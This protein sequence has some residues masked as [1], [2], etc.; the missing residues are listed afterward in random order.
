MIFE[1][2]ARQFTTIAQCN[3]ALSDNV[4]LRHKNAILNRKTQIKNIIDSSNREAYKIDNL[5][6]DFV[7]NFNIDEDY[8]LFE[9]TEE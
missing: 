4:E 7:D 2:W 8:K 1:S 5:K 9:G 6:A 3:E